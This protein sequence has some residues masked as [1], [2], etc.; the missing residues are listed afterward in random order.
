MSIFSPP[1][2]DLP[3]PPSFCAISCSGRHYISAVVANLQISFVLIPEGG[4]PFRSFLLY[5]FFQFSGN[6]HQNHSKL[7]PIPTTFPDPSSWLANVTSPL[8]G[9][10]IQHGDGVV[11]RLGP[12]YWVIRWKVCCCQ[13]SPKCGSIQL[14]RRWTPT[15]F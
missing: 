15:S 10:V 2:I 7:S 9:P 14:Y 6:D 1:P 11:H 5:S 4:S 12:D 13:G 3:Y 8:Q